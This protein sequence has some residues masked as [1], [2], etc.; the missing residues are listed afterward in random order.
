MVRATLLDPSEFSV[1]EAIEGALVASPASIRLTA[2]AGFGKPIVAMLSEPESKD[3]YLASNA[4]STMGFSIPAAIA[5]VRASGEP[6]LAFLG[7][8]SLLMRVTE[9]A[10]TQDLAASLV[11]VAIMDESLSQIEIKQ[12][13]LNLK[14]VGVT[15]PPLSCTQL[16]EAVGVRGADV[17][18]R[19]GLEA[20]VAEAWTHSGVT[21][22]GAHVST[23]ASRRIYES[24][25]G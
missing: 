11:V 23:V 25:R 5:A 22:I 16:G 9:L 14:N 17:S 12:E 15:L 24:L 4:L 1:P 10:L 19:Q 6:V 2:D 3:H 21:L 18:D 13:R 20:A 7:D 8:G